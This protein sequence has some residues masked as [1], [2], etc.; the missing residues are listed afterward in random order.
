MFTQVFSKNTFLFFL[1]ISISLTG[2]AQKNSGDIDFSFNPNDKG[3]GT[4]IGFVN[5]SGDGDVR[6]MFRLPGGRWLVAGQFNYYKNTSS[7][8]DNIILIN[9]D[10]TED[11]TF[12]MSSKLRTYIIDQVII[13]PDKK[14]ILTGSDIY[15][16]GVDQRGLIRLNPDGTKDNTFNVGNG[17]S[18]MRINAMILLNNGDFLIGGTFTSYNSVAV[19]KIAKIKSNGTLDNTFNS[20]GSGFSGGD[21]TSMLLLSNGKIIVGGSFRSYNNVSDITGY[22]RLNSNGSADT[23]F[24]TT[25]DFYFSKTSSLALQSDGKII[26]GGLS[27]TSASNIMYN[28][29]LRL[30]TDG[31]IDTTFI[32]NPGAKGGKIKS[33]IV[34]PDDKIMISGDFKSCNNILSRGLQ[35]LNADGS[36][37]NSFR[38]DSSFNFNVN[39][40]AL[41]SNN[42][43][44]IQAIDTVYAKEY[45]NI[46]MFAR[47]NVDGSIDNSFNP[48]SGANESVKAIAVQTDSKILLA[49][50]FGM[51]NGTIRKDIIR[52]NPDGSLDES[53]KT[54]GIGFDGGIYK[55]I[56]QKDGKLLVAGYFNNY[57][58]K[59][60]PGIARL[61][62]NGSLDTS[63]K[64]FPG[65]VSPVSAIAL[66]SDGK[67]IATGSFV[68][69]AF[70]KKYQIFRMKSNG[71]M[72]STFA[73]NASANGFGSAAVLSLALQSD[74]KILAGGVFNFY[75]D[76]TQPK[77]MRFKSN[78]NI[79]SSFN[80]GNSSFNGTVYAVLA[81]PNGKI[82]VGGDF[83]SYNKN[84]YMRLIRLNT[85]GSPD[86]TMDVGGGFDQT[87]KSIGLQSDSKIMVMG[88]F[89]AFQG[90]GAA[91]VVRL[92]SNGTRDYNYIVTN[93]GPYAPETMVLQSDNKALIGGGFVE[94]NNKGRNRI[95]R[96]QSQCI[97]VNADKPVLK[98]V[99][100]EI[101]AG[102]S[103]LVVVSSGN[104][105]DAPFWVWR[106]NNCNIGTLQAFGDSVY[107]KPTT[108][109]TYYVRGEASCAGSGE[110]ESITITVKPESECKTGIVNQQALPALRAK[111]YPNPVST[112]AEIE[113][114]HATANQSYTLQV[115]NSIGILCR[116]LTINPTRTKVDLAELSEGIYFYRILENNIFKG[117]EDH[118]IISR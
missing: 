2:M 22:V 28:G 94:T 33:A 37:D 8:H 82:L 1:L 107:L 67:I 61:N 3:N 92:N 100:T 113:L 85:N 68:V 38:I 118:F 13:Q 39:Y 47:I 114:E 99:K 54:E 84:T 63:F 108:T 75:N 14:M 23:S 5:N 48:V 7:K 93:M 60:A 69:N 35:R 12:K 70:Q 80:S 109:T 89:S 56:I 4:E 29:I 9:A 30:N 52:V 72:D 25:A 40:L 16:D 15:Y 45:A 73:F 19:G 51:Y 76:F 74:G 49:G 97:E 71:S 83:T 62:T 117:T 115:Y 50:G 59:S 116:Q 32:A 46:N 103:C 102:D 55:I 27:Y 17:V 6:K 112:I 41:D 44:I 43:I 91:R 64:P 10:G 34:L 24:K 20:G 86:N 104:L 111:L 81:Q 98:A 65:L 21:V 90:G 105:N 42:K 66:Q 36:M 106:S 58:K 78:G 79:D 53:F 110:C 96:L 101:C 11:T 88:T 87:V 95:V 26:V 77:L 18:Y 57:N 31:N